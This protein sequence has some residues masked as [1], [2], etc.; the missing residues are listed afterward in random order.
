MLLVGGG[1]TKMVERLADFLGPALTG[2][3]A[4]SVTGGAAAVDVVSDVKDPE[5]VALL[6]MGV[7]VEVGVEVVAAATIGS[8]GSGL[9][10]VVK[11]VEGVAFFLAPALNVVLARSA[12]TA[13]RVLETNV[14]LLLFP[15][16]VA[17]RIDC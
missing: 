15:S 10:S 5:L 7:G 14:V 6:S 17:S 16:F 8:V 1:E 3:A 11:V 9:F 4:V 2:V 12:A 13:W